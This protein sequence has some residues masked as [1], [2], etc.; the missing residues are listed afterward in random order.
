MR[1][2]SSPSCRLWEMTAPKCA[3]FRAGHDKNSFDLVIAGGGYTGCSA[4]LA[5][6]QSGHSVC[7]LE[8]REIGF[9][10]S[11]RN[12]GLVNAGLWLPPRDIRRILGDE[13]GSRLSEALAGAPELV[14]SL[15]RDHDTDCEAVRN[16]T[17]HVAHSA[18]GFRDLVNRCEQLQE[19]GA[20]VELLNEDEA[21][22]RTGTD[23]VHGALFDPR[24]GTINPLAYCRGLAQAANREGAEI[25]ENT[26][27]TGAKHE[28]GRWTIETPGGTLDSKFLLV[29]TNAFHSGLKGIR[30]PEFVPV[31]YFQFAT[32]PLSGNLRKTVL[33]GLEGCW[34]T[35]KV[36]S[37]FRL[38]SAGRLILGSIGQL[39]HAASGVHERWARR[40][41]RSL[42]PALED[43]PFDYAWHGRIAM[44][45]DH[46]PKILEIGPGGLAIFG[47]S[48]RGI[49]PGTLFGKAAA[50]F[51][52]TGDR[53]V[54]PVRPVSDHTEHL[55]GL[56]QL[57][58][59]AGA[60]ATHLTR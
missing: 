1:S 27:V 54:L 10:G 9:G 41:L 48:G 39:D 47:Y 14:F 55:T 20:P 35:A 46:I 31:H 2:S 44:T 15:I 38:D 50:R 11:G 59:E 6:A 8:A 25:R 26:P 17:L 33:P 58:Y 13:A 40:K 60:V 34:D 43:I 29:S 56:K 49:G 53:G 42:Y 12:V 5:A 24:A 19:T 51:F 22:A 52:S 23:A 4:A 37:S 57:W 21:R 7:L 30:K 18:D 3:P 28:N 36:M 45:A 32:E 16:G